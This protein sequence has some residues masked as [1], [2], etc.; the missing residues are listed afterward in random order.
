VG[1]GTTFKVYLPQVDEAAKP[2]MEGG[3]E[4]T[5]VAGTEVILLVEDEDM[6]RELAHRLLGDM[7]YTV[8]EARNGE[9]A[10]RQAESHRG[11][12]HLLVTDMVM[13]G[14]GGHEL[15]EKVTAA[16]PDTK[17]LYVSGYTSD[18]V[19]RRWTM[20]GATAFLQKPYDPLTLTQKVR[21]VLDARVR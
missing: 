6:V 18:T 5:L 15:A 11:P 2:V 16:R 3:A 20:Q 8:L 7:G 9:A 10:L 4:P 19:V 14:I 13:P 1:K 21:E 17:V 12:I